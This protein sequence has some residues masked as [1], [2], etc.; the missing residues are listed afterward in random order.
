MVPPGAARANITDQNERITVV[1]VNGA[2]YEWTIIVM[3]LMPVLDFITT[4]TLLSL[5][6]WAFRKHFET[7][8]E[9]KLCCI[10]TGNC[11]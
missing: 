4:G 10:S 3:S 7:E 8:V 2:C 11:I 6:C 1:D 9:S 5:Q